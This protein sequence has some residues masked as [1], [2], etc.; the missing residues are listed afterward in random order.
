MTNHWVDI[1]NAD[2]ILVMGGNAAEAHPCGFKWVVEAKAHRGARLVVVDPRYTRTA[3][4]ADYYAPIRTGTD[5]AFLGG[6]INYLLT[7]NQIQ[8]EYVKH[9]TDFSFIVREDFAFENGL[10]SG[11]D[12]A[13]RAYDRSTWEYEFDETGYVKADETLS[14]PRCVYQLMKNHFSRYT[15]EMVEKICGTPREKFLHVCEILA[16]TAVPNRAGTVLYALGWTHH[17]IGSQIIRTGAMV[18]LLLGN[19]GI[20][21]GGV[22]AL[23]GHSN[24]QG[25]TDLGL[26]SEMLPGYM[27]LPWENEQDYEAYIQHHALKPL[28][29]NQLSYYQNYRAFFVSMMKSW[30]GDTATKENNWAYDY[31]PK[32][33][34]TYDLIQNVESMSQGKMTG[35]VCQGF[36]M[37]ASAPNKA[38]VF[39]GLCK[40]K[41]LVIM[42]PLATETSEFW[43]DFGD[44]H[45]ADS[46]KIQTEVFR[47]PT[48]CFAEEN[49]SVVSSS[50]V[51]QWHWKG[52]EPPGDA[53]GDAEIMSNL[54]L[55]LRERYRSEGGAWSEPIL[56]LNWPYANPASPTPEELAKEYNGSALSDLEDPRSPGKLAVRAGQQLAGFSQLRDDGSTASG[57]WVFCGA[58]TEAGN[59][60]ARRDNSDP[61]NIGQSLGWAWAWPD[62]RRILYNRASCDLNGQPFDPSRAI[63]K[64]DGK[65]W[66]GADVIDYEKDEAPSLGMGPF[67]MNP[68][69]VARFFARARMN[70]GPFPEHYEPFETPLGF[71]PLHPDHPEVTNNPVARVF[72]R[73]RKDF[74]TAAE[75]PYTATTYRLTEHFHFWTKHARLN[76]II[77]PEQFVEI[78]DELANELRI[79]SGD[80]V[81]VSSRRGHI[82]AIALV[83]KRIQPLRVDGRT[84]HTV[85]VPLHWGYKGLAKPGYLA[86]TL[87]PSVG[88]ANTQTPEFKS[89]LVKVEKV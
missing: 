40:L 36:N 31:L 69:G 19:I 75:F 88:D 50:R 41:W 59:M 64:W 72:A 24:I 82:I 67:I 26:L 53:L 1:R 43:K 6:V 89:F 25:L 33:D 23:R 61:T 77:Q 4:V 84:V 2:V 66:S 16:S 58:W 83:T 54:F 49:G 60:M 74:G 48:T 71:N 51:L 15:P 11:Y 87:T 68:E 42:D 5:I 29:P 17:S 38:K 80:T 34:K 22:N 70:E 10:Y 56:K 9:Y 85:G 28:R 35:Y 78:G 62:N 37:I 21:G 65:Q 39:E 20:S 57:C 7:T 46:S 18:Q 14:H 55:R 86:N 79:V 30:W 81:R 32:P 8:H 27:E 3:S 73:D 44:Y 76:A 13:K 12:A 52:A 63:V 47:L 45:K